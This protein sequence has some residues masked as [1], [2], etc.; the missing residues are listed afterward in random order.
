M[1]PL[2]QSDK[3]LIE[4]IYSQ[5]Q[6]NDPVEIANCAIEFVH[7]GKTCEDS[8]RVTLQF[9]PSSQLLFLVQPA[10]NQPALYIELFVS[11]EWDGKLKIKDRESTFEA[12]F[13]GNR[14]SSGFA[15]VPRQSYI[16]PLQPS[17]KIVSVIFH[18]FN[19]PKF[20]GTDDYILNG[21]TPGDTCVRW[22][23]H[24]GGRRMEGNNIRHGQNPKSVRGTGQ[25]RGHGN[26][27]CGEN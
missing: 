27:T 10:T 18:L 3:I 11:N 16:S 4:P 2:L 20:Y 22:T 26:Y 21:S 17:D 13:V 7:S 9:L 25:R 19:W 6:P 1:G 5:M 8:C 14:G 12:L 24:I 23:N 15:F